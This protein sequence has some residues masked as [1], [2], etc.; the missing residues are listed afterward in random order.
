MNNLQ[1]QVDDW[2]KQY[3][4]EYFKPLEILA[5]LTEEVGEL[6]RELNHI[7]GPKKKKSSEDK[8]EMADE[9]GDII[10]T[11][12]CLANSH[13]VDL[14]DSFKKVMDKCYGRDKDR[15]EKKR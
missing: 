14:D 11:I 7:Y 6:A 3:K 15:W 13:K 8:K 5:R 9:M 2:V 4:V 10:F 12:I 1:K